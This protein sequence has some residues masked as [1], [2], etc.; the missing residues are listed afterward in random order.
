M[1]GIVPWRALQAVLWDSLRSIV[2]KVRSITPGPR[3][4]PANG[5]PVYVMLPLD[6]ALPTPQIK[7]DVLQSY[8]KRLAAIGVHGVMVDCWWR[9]CEPQPN[10]YDF[11]TYVELGKT[12]RSIGLKIQVVMSF[13]ACGGN[14]GDDVDIPLPEWVL[15]AGERRNIWFI[16]NYG[17]Q[18]SEYISFAYDNVPVLPSA[19][20]LSEPNSTRSRTPVQAYGQFTRAFV[21]AMQDAQ[22][23]NSTITELHLGLGPCGELHYPSYPSAHWKFPGIGAFQ[24]FDRSLDSEMALATDFTESDKIKAATTP[25]EDLG[26][27]NDSPSDTKFFQEKMYKQ[28]GRFFL[29]WYSGRLLTHAKDVLEEVRN[30]LG[31]DYQMV[32]MAVKIGGIHWWKLSPSRAA[33]ATSGYIKEPGKPLYQ[34]IAR[35]LKDYNAIL[36]FTCLE[37]RSIDQPIQARCGPR[38]LVAEVFRCAKREGVPV[39]GENAIQRFDS[40]AFKQVAYAMKWCPGQKVGF[41]LLRLCDDLM[42]Q[43]NLHNLESFVKEMRRIDSTKM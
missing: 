38:Q 29:R 8:L 39:A 30:V 7:P 40:A 41:T 17:N 32:Q 35:V 22:L 25:P 34:D 2:H 43:E 37:M 21:S 15:E 6:I 24:C 18:N 13:H 1:L 20:P 33:E 36:N 11:S 4:L 26:T 42:T 31:E 28:E 16:D 23:L 9:L 10:Q 14:I 3:T 27:Y 5:V 19:A 12:C